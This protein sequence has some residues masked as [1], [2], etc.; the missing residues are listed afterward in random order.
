M[1]CDL[2]IYAA[3]FCSG[4][5]TRLSHFL[6]LTDILCLHVQFY[7]EREAPEKRLD[8][9]GGYHGATLDPENFHWGYPKQSWPLSQVV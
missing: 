2:W 7:A 4:S 9:N 5:M 1:F 3:E 6:R 8:K